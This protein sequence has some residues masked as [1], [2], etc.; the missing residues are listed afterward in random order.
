MATKKKT[1][2]NYQ[3]VY[4]DFAHDVDTTLYNL[5]ELKDDVFNGTITNKDMIEKLF[6]ITAQLNRAFEDSEQKIY[7][8]D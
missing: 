2:I 3:K 1:T 4:K 6:E 5:H 8:E 7:G